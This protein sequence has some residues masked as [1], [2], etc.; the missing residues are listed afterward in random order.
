MVIKR[1]LFKFNIVIIN[2]TLTLK[3]QYFYLGYINSVL[4]ILLSPKIIFNRMLIEIF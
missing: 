2:I 1:C 4:F 3:R